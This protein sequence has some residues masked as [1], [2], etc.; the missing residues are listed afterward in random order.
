MS[1]IFI[2]CSLLLLSSLPA[3]AEARI[4]WRPGR[5]ADR[6]GRPG[7]NRPPVQRIVYQTLETFRVQKLVETTNTVRVNHPNVKVVQFTAIDN[8][9]EIVEARLLLDNG[10]E[11]Y[12]DG[13]TGGL[14]R[15][16]TINYTLDGPWGERVQSILIRAVSRSLIG[17][18]PSLQVT[19]GV[20]Q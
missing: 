4:E 9:V 19:V 18:R 1:K 7:D 14:G 17:S 20:L 8:D 6:P 5:P 11:V 15:N 13:A 2:L 12:M 16:R 3:L 10:R